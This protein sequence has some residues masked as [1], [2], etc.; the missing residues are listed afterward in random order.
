MRK[1]HK[2]LYKAGKNWLTATITVTAVT[3]MGVQTAHADTSAENSTSAQV[4]STNDSGVAHTP[5]EGNSHENDGI[6]ATPTPASAEENSVQTG[7]STTVND[8][9]ASPQ[10]DSNIYGTVNVK[11]WD[12]ENNSDIFNLTGYHGQDTRHI[13]VPNLNDFNDAGIEIG[14]TTSVGISS[15]L[16]KNL[17][18]QSI[19]FAISKT[20]GEYNNKVIATDNDWSSVFANTGLVNA[21]LSNLDTRNI[22]D[23]SYLFN[24][25]KGLKTI[26][27]LSQWDTSHVNKMGFMFSGTSMLQTAGSIGQWDT[28]N[29]TSMWG[30]FNESS[31]NTKGIGQWNTSNVTDMSWMFQ[32]YKG[33]WGELSSWDVSNVKDMHGMFAY[34]N[35][36]DQMSNP[37]DLTKWRVANGANLNEMMDASVPFYKVVASNENGVIPNQVTIKDN[38]GNV[39]AIIDTPTIYYTNKSVKSAVDE[40]VQAEVD[41]LNKSAKIS[42]GIP[43][44]VSSKDDDYSIANAVYVVGNEQSGSINYVDQDSKIVKTDTISGNVGDTINLSISLPDGYELADNNEKLPTKVTVTNSGI[45]AI[46][47]K[48]KHQTV[49]LDPWNLPAG[50]DQNQF[51]RE[52]TRTI[53]INTPQQKNN[54]IIQKVTISRYGT[55]DQVTKKVT[56]GDWSTSQFESM[57]VP[58]ILGYKLDQNTISAEKV[59]SNSKNSTITINAVPL[60]QTLNI[61]Y[62]DGMQLVSQE[63]LKGKTGETIKLT[64]CLHLPAGY[65]INHFFPPK[66]DYTFKAGDDSITVDLEHIIS[67]FDNKTPDDQLPSGITPADFQ[68]QVTRTITINRPHKEPEVYVQTSNL[69]RQGDYD[70]VTKQITYSDWS[71][72]T[73]KSYTA[74]IISGYVA[75]EPVINSLEVNYN[76]ENQYVVVNYIADSQTGSINYVDQD[77]K[78]IKT[79]TIS[80]N[81]GDTINLNISLPD[82]YEIDDSDTDL[83]TTVTVTAS[84]IPTITINVKHQIVYIDQWDIPAGYDKS[85]FLREVTRTIVINAPQQK[86]KDIVQSVR[87][88]RNATLDKVT[89]KVTFGDWRTS[90]FRAVNIPSVP[91]YKPD[92]SVVPLEKVDSDTKNS[93]IEINYTPLEQTVTVYYFGMVMGPI[94][95]DYI[96]GKTGQT[97]EYQVKLPQGYKLASSQSAK[98]SYTFTGYDHQSMSIYIEPIIM[99]LDSTTPANKLP[100]NFKLSDFSKTITRTITLE[101]PNGKPQEV[102][103]EVTLTRAADYNEGTKEANYTNWTTGKFNLYKAPV[104]QGYIATQP[105]VNSMQIDHD[106]DD[107]FVVINY[108]ANRQYSHINYIDEDGKVI[109][110]D[111]VSGVVGTS[112]PVKIV[113]PDGYELANKDEQLPTTIKIDNDQL[114]DLTIKVK[115]IA[116]P[117]QSADN[118]VPQDHTTQNNQINFNQGWLDNYG[119]TQTK[120]GLSQIKASG[121]HAVGQSNQDP[122]RYMIVYDNTLGHE[123]A[124]Q[125]LIPVVRNDVRQAYS[126]ITNSNYSGFDMTIDIPTSAINHSLSLVARYS[127][128]AVNGEGQHVDYWF[129]PLKMDDSNQGYLD[130]IES[131]GKTVTISGWHATNQAANRPY[132]Y[133]IA[134]DQ[135]LG[136]EIARQKVESVQRPDVAKVYG[137]IANAINS[138]YSAK[139]N[140]TSQY[141]NDNIQFLSRWTDD[142]NGNGNSVD[143]WFNPVNRINRANLDSVDLSSGELKVTG[144]HATDM[145]EFEPNHFLI[146][147]D[148]TTGQQVASQKVELES[149]VDVAKVYSDTRTANHSRFNF[150][151]GALNLQP[152]HNYSLVSRY[153]TDGNGNGNDGAHTDSWLNM[154]IFSQKAHNL[155]SAVLNGNT[156]TFQGWMADDQATIKQYPYAI[157]LQN[158]KEIARQ[159][160]DLTTRPDVAKVY[161]RLYQSKK[162]GF[163]ASFKLPTVSLDNLQLVLRYTDSKDGNGNPSD[164]WIDINRGMIKKI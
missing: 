74:P 121:W 163:N 93:K 14:Q 128:D 106:T 152:G 92:Q 68:K 58:S 29:V 127:D 43:K 131:D 94:K 95:T 28:S 87:I 110:T 26:G 33:M 83:P 46:T 122:Y 53:I 156:L 41:K 101:M 144:W 47:V 31:I 21:D 67:H 4:V 61:S 57:D 39:L 24:S 16:T 147:F 109:K 149:S 89:K 64:S 112:I 103:Q 111:T 126:N 62:R 159:Q 145:S 155:D 124:R 138:G 153:S 115:K 158:G 116:S 10:V 38:S 129:G 66:E 12:Y 142:P 8:Q 99:H 84:G 54:P 134:F 5:S 17:V 56:F 96:S 85:Q 80:G 160:L 82:G 15:T 59:D 18:S 88:Y 71:T 146:V 55:L 36:I 137:K 132:H 35:Q 86:P 51:V 45:P 73:F 27:D 135:T 65:Q 72:G 162:S 114:Q 30:M 25:S 1:E 113:I 91:G 32:N 7:S 40:I 78:V 90:E 23:M 123:I 120:D 125:K 13:V 102:K 34:P 48:V 140:L 118:Q 19:A 164:A 42:Y 148:N 60:E 79:D 139:F 49:S 50:Y 154:G 76:T 22:T 150:N 130:S 97:I 6:I 104:I 11:D 141:F 119:L 63:T 9:Q 108:I 77:G 161:P 37:G 75:T 100:D 133:I 157:L 81:I 98:V 143:Y 20:S 52:V 2:K 151:F 136:H 70:Q 44:I 3:F 117:S 107:Q 69:T 105:V